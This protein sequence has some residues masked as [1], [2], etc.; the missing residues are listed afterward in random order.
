MSNECDSEERPVHNLKILAKYFKEVKDGKKKFELRKDDRGFNVGDTVV[1]NELD[2]DDLTGRNIIGFIS[3]ILRNA[4][5]Y[6]LDDDYCIF[7]LEQMTYS[8]HVR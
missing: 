2:G 8:R 4:E 1:L 7:S 5:L 3:Y 6:G